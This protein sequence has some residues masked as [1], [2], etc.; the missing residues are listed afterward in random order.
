LYP[1]QLL[2]PIYFIRVTR[3]IYVVEDC[4]TEG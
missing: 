4:L 1:Q 3:A 2:D